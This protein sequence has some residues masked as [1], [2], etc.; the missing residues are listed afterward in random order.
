MLLNLM[1]CIP[2]RL[3]FTQLTRGQWPSNVRNRTP[4]ERECAIKVRRLT[5]LLYDT[6]PIQCMSRAIQPPILHDTLCSLLSDHT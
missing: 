3:N 1:Q 4:E 2:D 5:A 6:D